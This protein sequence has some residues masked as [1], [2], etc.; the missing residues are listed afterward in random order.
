MKKLPKISIVIPTYNSSQYLE[1][2]LDSIYS[3]DYPLDK[4]EVW[5]VNSVA[6]TDN[7]IEIAKKYPVKILSNPKKLAEP[8]KTLG[9]KHSTGDL[10]MYMDSD[11]ELVS[12]TW[13]KDMSHPLM[14]DTEL[15]G[16]FTRFVVNPK[17]KAFNRYVTFN[18]LQ[19]WPMLA[20][21]LPTVK[22][23]TV[24][25]K[26]NYDVVKVDPHRCV[27]I[28]MG[29]YRKIWLDKVIKN[30]DTFNYV[31]IAI[32]IQLSEIGHDKLAYVD[33]A[34]YYH[35]RESLIHEMHRQKR[36]VAVT[37][38]PI[39]GQRRFHY[40]DFTKPGDLLKIVTWIV[41][42]N[43]LFPS[44]LVGIYKTIKYRDWVGMYELP[45]CFLLTNY[46]IYLFLT[47][48]NGHKLLKSILLR[49]P[50]S[51][52]KSQTPRNSFGINRLKH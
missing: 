1:S 4:L 28:G 44:F 5:V 30:P 21:L 31:D 16:S 25:K 36:D 14:E 20:F 34:G 9:F 35:I 18:P 10:F 43:L 42:V 47:E 32:P 6:T 51:S 45:A 48:S 46:V 12:R 52:I 19:L 7:T 15:V 11:A 3:Q 22:E 37:Y 40:V 23:V 27:P 17:H 39:V 2:C 29:M 24:D 38:L 13:F 26:V 41:Y 49:Q 50:I 8:A 33:S